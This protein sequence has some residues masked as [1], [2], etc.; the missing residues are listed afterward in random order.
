MGADIVHHRRF[1]PT[2]AEVQGV[3]GDIGPGKGYGSGITAAGQVFDDHPPRV[4]QPQILGHF[5]E[6][7][8]GRIVPGPAQRAKGRKTLSQIERGMS[9]GGDHADKGEGHLLFRKDGQQ[10]P[11]QVIHPHEREGLGM[12]DGLG[13]H[14]PHQEGA[15]QARPTGYGY[16]IYF[17]Q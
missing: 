9:P 17:V 4:S 14:D 1:D 12:G 6:G 5:V 13:G 11:H 16:S 10:V 2:E 3:L 15:H 7:L 8:P